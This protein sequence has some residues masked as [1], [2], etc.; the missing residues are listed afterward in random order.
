MAWGITELY[1]SVLSENRK[2]RKRKQDMAD[3]P[4]EVYCWAVNQDPKPPW[5]QTIQTY[6][7]KG[8]IN[9]GC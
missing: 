1:Y 9:Y 6:L 8:E 5:L 4:T 7:E 3:L 2:L